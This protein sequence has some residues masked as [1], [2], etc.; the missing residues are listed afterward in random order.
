MDDVEFISRQKSEIYQIYN[1]IDQQSKALENTLPLRIVLEIHYKH[2]RM[3]DAQFKQYEEVLEMLE[4]QQIEN[5]SPEYEL[6]FILKECFS[7]REVR[8]KD[9][10]LPLEK[11]C[12][13]LRSNSGS[14]G[15]MNEKSLSQFL[16]QYGLIHDK[17]RKRYA[18]TD[19]KAPAKKIQVQRTCIRKNKSKL[20]KLLKKGEKNELSIPH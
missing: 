11:I 4:T 12:E 2:R 17:A 9:G 7:V 10:W 6:L 13:Y 8:V 3:S 20:N 15:I 5:T 19:S 1:Q 18:E 16:N 14:Y